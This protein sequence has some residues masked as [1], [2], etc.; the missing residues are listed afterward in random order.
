MMASVIIIVKYKSKKTVKQFLTITLPIFIL[1]LLYFWNLDFNNYI[2][3]YLFSSHAYE[4]EYSEELEELSIPLPNRT[5]LKG[6]E[7]FCSPFYITYVD[8]QDFIDFYQ[9]ELKKLKSSGQIEEYKYLEVEVEEEK[10]STKGYIIELSSG[11]EIEIVI[12][13]YEDNNEWF[14]SVDYHPNSDSS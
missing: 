13:Q 14:I 5:V 8:D 2:K 6:R 4:C 3:S 10:L 12:Y 11:S 9:V 7:D 1:I